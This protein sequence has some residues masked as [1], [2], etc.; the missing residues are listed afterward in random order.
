MTNSQSCD[1]LFMM[2]IKLLTLGLRASNYTKFTGKINQKSL[3]VLMN[4]IYG[5]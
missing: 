4:S 5:F 1:S 2:S 3:A